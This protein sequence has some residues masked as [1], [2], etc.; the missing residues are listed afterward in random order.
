MKCA[1]Q[2]VLQKDGTRSDTICLDRVSFANWLFEN[3][4]DEVDLFYVLVLCEFNSRVT[5]SPDW[6][7]STAPLMTVRQFVQVVVGREYPPVEQPVLDA[8]T[9][10]CV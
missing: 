2:L 6:D 8:S 9:D 10:A 3:F 4:Q 1:F 7:F 5:D